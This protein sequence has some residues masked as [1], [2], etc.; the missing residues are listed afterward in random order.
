MAADCVVYNAMNIFKRESCQMKRILSAAPVI[1]M[2]LGLMC[3]GAGAAA[4]QTGTASVSGG[5]VADTGH[6]VPGA[7][8]TVMAVPA[9]IPPPAGFT[10]LT[11]NAFA[12]SDGTFSV[13]SLPAGK[14]QLCAQ[15]QR[16]AALLDPCLWSTSQTFVTLAAGQA[17]SGQ[18]ITLISGTLLKLYINDPGGLMLANDGKT[19]GAGMIVAV[20]GSTNIL[21]PFFVDATTAT[22]REHS[23]AV[24]AGTPLKLVVFSA[25]YRIADASGNAVTG[26]YSAPVS[27]ATA[28]AAS[29][30]TLT[31][32]ITGLQGH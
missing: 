19:P 26:T 28:T 2:C 15:T 17:V 13:G 11:T 12:A 3:L 32:N 1:V 30:T 6:A 16:T 18:R 9:T 8:V 23:L 21:T 29:P 4:G 31:I 5:M 24:P 7:L 25:F 10:P 27:V 14:Y 22:G 20:G